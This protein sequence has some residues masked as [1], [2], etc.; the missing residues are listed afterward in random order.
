MSTQDILKEAAGPNKM[1]LVEFYEF[2][3]RIAYEC[4]KDHQEMHTELLHL[5]I[6]ALL[7]RLFKIVKFQK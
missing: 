6:D 3:A 7:T 2:L 5:K 4:F 1:Q